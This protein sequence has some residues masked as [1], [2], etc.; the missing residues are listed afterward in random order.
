MSGLGETRCREILEVAPD[1][2][3]DEV[4]RSYGFLRGLYGPGASVL[5]AAGM[6]E[7]SPEAQARVLA[8][9]EAAYLELCGLLETA[10]PPPPPRRILPAPDQI[11]DGPGLRRVREAAG[12]TLEYLAA[13]TSVRQA[14][15]AALEEER[16]NDL[17]AAA[18]IVRGYL[19]AYLAALG[20]DSEATVIDYVRRCQGR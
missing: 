8:E 14:F 3:L 5:G 6:D 4:R 18:V 11:L 2:G 7:F 16:F 10:A 15:L 1:A 20:M 12:F 19:T 9:V 13:E 17:P